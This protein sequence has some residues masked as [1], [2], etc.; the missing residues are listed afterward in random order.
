MHLVVLRLIPWQ[1]A[2]ETIVSVMIAGISE[3]FM[4]G[5]LV[6]AAAW[7]VAGTA[8]SWLTCRERRHLSGMHARTA[9]RVQPIIDKVAAEHCDVDLGVD[10][11]V[12]SR[13]GFDNVGR[14]IIA[15]SVP[16]RSIFGSRTQDFFQFF[17][18]SAN[19][20]DASN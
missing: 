1:P 8:L 15:S 20:A 19:L 16:E 11:G 3:N 7:N 13:A 18:F 17:T 2:R 5:Y 12:E 14:P 4:D 9:H 10:D 6:Q